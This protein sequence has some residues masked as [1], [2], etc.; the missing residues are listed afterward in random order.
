MK[1][2]RWTLLL[3]IAAGLLLTATTQAQSQTLYWERFDVNITVMENGDFVV[4]EDQ[5]I[6]FTSGQF[7]FG[8]RNIPHGPAGGYHGR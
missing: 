1:H 3:T 5:R 4:E 2:I 7:H 6:V 8:Y